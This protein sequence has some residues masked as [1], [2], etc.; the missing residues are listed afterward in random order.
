M[1]QDVI[2]TSSGPVSMHVP[3]IAVYVFVW[4]ESID[5]YVWFKQKISIT[6]IKMNVIM[7]IVM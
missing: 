1:I 2:V 6:Y 3:K 7:I 5:A 4:K